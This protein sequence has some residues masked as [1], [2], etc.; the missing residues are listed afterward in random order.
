MKKMLKSKLILFLGKVL[1]DESFLK[2]KFLYFHKKFLNLNNPKTFGEKIQW[3]KLYGNLDK[4]SSY[5]CKYEVRNFISSKIGDKYLIPLIGVYEEVNDIDFNALPNKFVLKLTSG[6]GYNYIVENKDKADI[7]DIKDKLNKW[8]KEDF[9]KK[10]KETQYKNLKQ[11]IICESFISDNN[12]A[13]V[14]YKFY[15]FNGKIDFIQVYEGKKETQINKTKGKKKNKEFLNVFND[16]W[17][18]IDLSYVGNLYD[19]K[20][21]E[22]SE[23]INFNEMLE[24]VKK[25]SEDFP[26]VRVDLYNLDG[27]IYFGE[28][29]FTPA[30]GTRRFSP[31]E[32]D[33]RISDLIDLSKYPKIEMSN[34]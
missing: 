4:Y 28:L 23:P 3:I 31:T 1:S 27:V 15:C 8:M 6:S 5:V 24:V 16:Q 17:K 7:Q 9:Y 2:L 12:N 29:T 34:E 26:F 19:K 21:E 13:L 18:E 22:I 33:L 30:D 25:L 11:K 14:D 10:G 32:E 20:L